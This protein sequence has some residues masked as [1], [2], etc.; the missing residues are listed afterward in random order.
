MWNPF[1]L[2][3]RSLPIR[4]ELPDYPAEKVCPIC[5]GTGTYVKAGVVEVCLCADYGEDVVYRVDTNGA[6]VPYKHRRIL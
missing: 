2:I 5:Q 4:R 6:A 1:E 3:L